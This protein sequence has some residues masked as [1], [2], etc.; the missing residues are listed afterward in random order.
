[1]RKA[2]VSIGQRYVAKVSGRIVAVRLTGENP[3]GGWD[4]VNE[5]TGRTVRIRTAAKLRR[6][7][8]PRAEAEELRA[9]GPTYFNRPVDTVTFLCTV[10]DGYVKVIRRADGATICAAPAPAEGRAV[11]RGLEFTRPE[12]QRC[13]RTRQA[14]ARALQAAGYF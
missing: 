9:T 12:F 11:L 5:D 8:A 1:M 10:A 3:Y 6:S 4:A 14:A 7:A 13:N 2:D